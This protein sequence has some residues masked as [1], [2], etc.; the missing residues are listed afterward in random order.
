MGAFS[1]SPGTLQ[2]AGG[3]VRDCAAR[4]ASARGVLART[5]SI[6][7]AFGDARAAGAYDGAY[8]AMSQGLDALGAAVQRL[9]SRLTGAGSAYSGGDAAIGA[10]G[11]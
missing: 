9:G 10:E 8:S 1:V 3:P 6:G 11:R 4:I 2:Q 5:G 7:S